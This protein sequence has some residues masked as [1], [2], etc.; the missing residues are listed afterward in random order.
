MIEAKAYVLRKTG[1][2]P[3]LEDIQVSDDLK[4]GQVM[5]RVL[6]SGLCATQ[7]EEIFVS[8]R[9]AK[10]MPHL[11]GHEGV[12]V[13][14]ALGPGVKTKK[15]G[16]IC[17]I[18]WRPSSIGMDSEPGDYF[19][20]QTKV[21][22]GKVVTFSTAVVV[23]ERNLTQLPSCVSPA[24]G[25]VLGCSLTTGWGSVVRL[26]EMKVGDIVV[27]TGVGAVG[28]S[29]ALVAL[30]GG[31]EKV[32][33]VDPRKPA[34]NILK[35][36]RVQHFQLLEDALAHIAGAS[37]QDANVIAI[38]TS[39]DQMTI[40]KLVDF[41]PAAS[42]LVLVGMPRGG[43]GSVINTQKLLDG[44]KVI[45]SNGGNVDPGVDLQQIVSMSK[46]RLLSDLTQPIKISKLGD[47]NSAITNQIQS[48]AKQILN[49]AINLS[50]KVG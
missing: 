30:L 21:S 17:V 44:L 28:T 47:L 5:L 48:N 26:G 16:D 2:I 13:V 19:V 8:S 35:N 7:M 25:S 11:F 42:K 32:L 22:S 45:G 23:P 39:G 40:S 38:E 20:N 33:T 4:P 27:I 14:E 3:S 43:A 15:L 9:N 50:R 37:R 1:E 49:L 31:A 41:L 12:G 34:N 46:S 29:A 36:N 24:A 18:H 6:Y 10:Y